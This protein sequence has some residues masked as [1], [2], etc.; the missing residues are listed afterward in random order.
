M[1]DMDLR[2]LR[3]QTEQ[4]KRFL[5][6][7]QRH[8]R[9][10]QQITDEIAAFRDRQM[11]VSAKSGDGMPRS[12]G[13]SDLSGY[14]AKLDGMTRNLADEREQCM[15]AYQEVV[16]QIQRLGSRREMDVLFYRYIDGYDWN[17]VAER[18]DLSARTVLR[19]HGRALVH[20][21]LP[22]KSKNH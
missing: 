14:V 5:R 19:V 8:V 21:Q 10:V 22:Q 11:R 4:K 18:M 3:A 1:S 16:R 17:Q 2:D 20:I 9:R 13:H 12:G 6:S 7:Y 15:R